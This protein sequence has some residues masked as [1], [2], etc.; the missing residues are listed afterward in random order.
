MANAVL[1]HPRR[2]IVLLCALVV[3]AASLLLPG[4]ASAAP[5]PITVANGEKAQFIS[6]FQINV[7]LTLACTAGSGYSLSVSVVQPQG[8]QF[9]LFGG[10]NASG[11][12]TGQQQKLAVPAFPF[13][14][15]PGFG[16][17]LGDAVATVDACQFAPFA[18]NGDTKAIH[19]VS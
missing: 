7:P 18:C 17:T 1:G 4:A 2:S 8:F 3:V 10:G 13:T 6:P 11:Q 19:I 5:N 16:W 9:T 15:F 12:C 14:P